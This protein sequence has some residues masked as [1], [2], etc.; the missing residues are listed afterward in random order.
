MFLDPPRDRTGACAMP[1]QL[2]PTLSSTHS[3]HCSS[4]FRF[5]QIKIRDPRILEGHPKKELQWRLQSKVNPKLWPSQ[6]QAHRSGKAASSIEK[7]PAH[8]QG[9]RFRV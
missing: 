2:S 7:A 8:V 1:Q 4:V 9:L 5:K 6:A 3:L